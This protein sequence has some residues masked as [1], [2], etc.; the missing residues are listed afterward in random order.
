V[1]TVSEKTTKTSV[2]AT[3]VSIYGVT[4]GLI[5]KISKDKTISVDYVG[6]VSNVPEEMEVTS[7]LEKA[8]YGFK[9][10]P[11]LALGM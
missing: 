1:I 3:E 8:I 6:V 9:R 11:T 10:T 4:F 2:D 5:K 7:W